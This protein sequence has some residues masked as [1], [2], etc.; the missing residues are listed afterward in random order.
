MGAGVAGLLMLTIGIVV[1]GFFKL[2]GIKF[3]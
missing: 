2:V 3:E 1:I